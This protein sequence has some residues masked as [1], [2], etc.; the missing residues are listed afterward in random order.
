MHAFGVQIN[1]EAVREARD[2]WALAYS[3]FSSDVDFVMTRLLNEAAVARMSPEQVAEASGLTVKRVRH[4]MRGIGLNPK[5][6]KT[7]LSQSAA[8]A[9]QENA[10]LLG[11]EPWE[12]DLMSP[13]AYL[14]MGSELRQ[15][16]LDEPPVSGNDPEW[17]DTGE[18][19]FSALVDDLHLFLDGCF[20]R[21]VSET[22]ATGLIENGWH[23]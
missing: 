1:L 22:I 9:L 20:E 8:E 10:A 12:V 11:I 17:D 16:I 19:M 7:L 14:P 6:S 23:K 4:L 13:L 2:K 3:R 18:K 15:Q 5:Q 21:E